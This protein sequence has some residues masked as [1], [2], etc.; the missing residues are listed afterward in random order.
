MKYNFKLIAIDFYIGK[1]YTAVA[2]GEAKGLPFYHI[3]WKL[4]HKAFTLQQ[5][6]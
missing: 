2:E 5:Y 3:V 6:Y 4:N 1:Q